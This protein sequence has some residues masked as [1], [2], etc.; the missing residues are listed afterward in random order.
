MSIG[1]AREGAKMNAWR[2]WWPDL[3]IV[4]GVT[5]LAFACSA[6]AGDGNVEGELDQGGGDVAGE[7][8]IGYTQNERVAVAAATALTTIGMLGKINQR[9]SSPSV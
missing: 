4:V 2:R 6:Y 8:S 5:W 7:L 3:L 9:R 1:A